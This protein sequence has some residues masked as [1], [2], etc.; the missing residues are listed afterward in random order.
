MS[1]LVSAFIGFII[2]VVLEGIREEMYCP[3]AYLEVD[4]C[5]GPNWDFRSHFVCSIVGA[6][7]A[8][9]SISLVP[10]FQEKNREVAVFSMLFVGLIVA[11][12]IAVLI[13]SGWSYLATAASGI[14]TFWTVKRLTSLGTRTV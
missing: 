2:F 6:S 11:A 8:F 14:L 5:Y 12:P 9:V 13:E 10:L 4:G 3:S 7:M 1:L